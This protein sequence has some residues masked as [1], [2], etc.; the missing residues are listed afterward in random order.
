MSN[1]ASVSSASVSSDS[2]QPTSIKVNVVTGQGGGGHYAA[3]RALAAIA[4][5]QHLPWDFQVTDMDD[6]ITALTAQN[7]I[8]NAYELFG[9]SGH[10]LYNLM[11][12]S[13]WTWLWPLKMRLKKFKAKLN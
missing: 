6:I 5:Q 1:T 13:G 7:E 9:M 10:N 4:Q 3:Y 2:S 8:Q 11:L 12:K